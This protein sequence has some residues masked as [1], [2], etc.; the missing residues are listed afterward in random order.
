MLRTLI[1]LLAATLA[2]TVCEAGN[3]QT[4]KVELRGQSQ[5]QPAQAVKLR[6]ISQITAPERLAQKIGDVVLAMAPLPGAQK[7]FTSD[8]VRLRIKASEPGANVTVTGPDK[9]ELMGRCARWSADE[10][11]K[12]AEEFIKNALPPDDGTYEVQ[13]GRTPKELLTASGDNSALRARLLSSA[14]RTG[15]NTVAV[16]AMVDSRA[17]ATTSVTVQVR[18]VAEVLTTTAAIRQGDALTT[19][20]T[21]WALRDFGRMTGVITRS[22]STSGQE[23]VARRTI[24]SGAVITAADVQAP[25]IIKR[26]DTVSLVVKCG[27]VRLVTT[28]E[29]KN[30]ARTGE[31]VS[32]RPATAD[33]DIRVLAVEPGLVEVT[34]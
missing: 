9:F 7:T 33:Q 8:Y 30:D 34:R 12:A 27:S 32:V 22:A 21:A 20:N 4:V 10:V 5:V 31:M 11:A 23:L 3:V 18:R 17:A 25:A 6:D 28:A 26:G 29:A 19:D 1:L 24:S 2:G 16:D 15:T 14:V 13:V